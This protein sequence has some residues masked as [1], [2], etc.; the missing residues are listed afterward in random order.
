MILVFQ[1]GKISDENTEFNVGDGFWDETNSFNH[2]QIV[3]TSGTLNGLNNNPDK[4]IPGTV[5]YETTFLA[6]GCQTIDPA[7]LI[8]LNT[9]YSADGHLIGSTTLDFELVVLPWESSVYDTRKNQSE[10]GVCV[11]VD[12][13]TTDSNGAPVVLVQKHFDF[14]VSILSSRFVSKSDLEETTSWITML[15]CS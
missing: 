3:D 12:I 14:S 10:F 4:S 6:P 8:S 9:K 13:V 2:I 11:Q 15:P 1:I 5:Y 7:N